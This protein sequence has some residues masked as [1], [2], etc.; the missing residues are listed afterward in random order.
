MPRLRTGA[1]N[2]G[3]VSTNDL[4]EELVGRG[5]AAIFGAHVT[6]ARGGG[7]GRICWRGKSDVC[8]GLAAAIFTHFERLEAALAKQ[9]NSL[10]RTGP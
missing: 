4:L 5:D 3:A 7:T 9:E 10:A 8:R 6:D 2:L 1:P